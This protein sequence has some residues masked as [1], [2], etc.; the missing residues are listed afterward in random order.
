MAILIVTIITT[1]F[2][3]SN[4]L[5]F[6]TFN[7]ISRLESLNHGALAICQLLRL[8]G[9]EHYDLVEWVL[10]GDDIVQFPCLSV[11]RDPLVVQ[12]DLFQL[13]C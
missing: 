13:L 3:F 9:I 11:I 4:W 5:N 1:N 12:I 2:S 8:Y 6:E 10:L 7:L